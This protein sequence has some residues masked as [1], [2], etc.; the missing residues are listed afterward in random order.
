MSVDNTPA[1]ERALRAEAAWLSQRLANLPPG[2][3]HALN[4]QGMLFRMRL[5]TDLAFYADVW[6]RIVNDERLWDQLAVFVDDVARNWAAKRPDVETRPR[7]KIKAKLAQRVQREYF[8][9][10]Y[11]P[12][13][14]DG[15]RHVYRTVFDPATPPP[16]PGAAVPM[17]IPMPSLETQLAFFRLIQLVPESFVVSRRIYE[18]WATSHGRRVS[19]E[20]DLYPLDAAEDDFLHDFA[21]I[22]TSRVIPNRFFLMKNP[23]QRDALLTGPSTLWLPLCPYAALRAALQRHVHPDRSLP[24]IVEEATRALIDMGAPRE[25]LQVIGE[26]LPPMQADGPVPPLL[27]HDRC[28]A[29]IDIGEWSSALAAATELEQ[30][31]DDDF[32]RFQAH[33]CAFQARRHLAAG[34]DD[35]AGARQLVQEAR[36]AGKPRERVARL[37]NAAVE[38]HAAQ[39]PRAMEEA[40]SAAT[41]ES[42]GD[43]EALQQVMAFQ[44]RP[45]G[46]PPRSGHLFGTPG[47]PFAAFAALTESYYALYPDERP[48]NTARASQSQGQSPKDPAGPMAGDQHHE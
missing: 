33:L 35:V 38:F 40:L 23:A 15:M 44:P 30:A 12:S 10:L 21:A 16:E 28:L 1:L 41:D 7:S 9:D 36:A 8:A 29:F 3:T 31:T 37:L 25:A 14:R 42:R 48:A 27:Y 4:M 26:Y 19:S 2:E 11:H 6:R 45:A 46:A 20:L 5:S 47:F 13:T 34:P 39:M 43:P 22:V 17:Q 24:A 18:M 32:L